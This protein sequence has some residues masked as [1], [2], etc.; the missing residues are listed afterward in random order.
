M[1]TNVS[2]QSYVDSLKW[3]T[4]S[5]VPDPNNNDQ[6]T[7]EDFFSLLTQQL[8]FQD[9]TKPAD[10][11]QIKNTSPYTRKAPYHYGWDWG[12]SFATSGI[13]QS[14]E[15]I[16]IGNW[17]IESIHIFQEKVSSNKAELALKLFVE[18]SIDADA[19]LLIIEKKSN[20]NRRMEAIWSTQVVVSHSNC[21]IVVYL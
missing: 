3:Q 20:I 4:P 18:S 21:S 14:V 19:E 2:N 10:N 9:P 7:Q 16:G 13:W 1:T 6:L 17:F 11:D 12:P 5:G 15:L 8:S